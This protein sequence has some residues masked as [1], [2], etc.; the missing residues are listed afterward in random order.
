MRIELTTDVALPVDEVFARFDRN[1]FLA[2]NPP[3]P[4]VRLERFDG[5]RTG[6]EVHLDLSFGLFR[7]RWKSVITAFGEDDAGVHFV[8]EGHILPFFLRTWRHEHRLERTAG[9][10]RIRDRI[11]YTAPAPWL[12]WLLYPVLYLQFLYRK[13]VYRRFLSGSS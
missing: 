11:D 7:Q 8:D 4:L 6:N 1:L 5:C 3:F 2:L 12:E 13:P 9:G 10:T